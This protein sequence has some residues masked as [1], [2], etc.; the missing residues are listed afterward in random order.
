MG[1]SGASGWT[2]EIGAACQRPEDLFSDHG[3]AAPNPVTLNET[4]D[5]SAASGPHLK[6]ETPGPTYPGVS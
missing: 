6:T 3:S 4:S 5:C 1:I 2:A